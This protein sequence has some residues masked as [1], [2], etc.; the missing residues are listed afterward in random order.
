MTYPPQVELLPINPPDLTE[1]ERL[2][3]QSRA[4]VFRV[5]AIPER[6]LIRKYDDFSCD[7]AKW[8]L[9]KL[10][11][12]RRNGMPAVLLEYERRTRD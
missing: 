9:D 11:H 1:F 5:M 8:S 3:E 10:I 12:E 4:E 6:Y 7:P 2:M